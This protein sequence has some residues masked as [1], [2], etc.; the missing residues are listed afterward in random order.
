MHSFALLPAAREIIA[1]TPVL[2]DLRTLAPVQHGNNTTVVR[3]YMGLQ[4]QIKFAHR[5]PGNVMVIIERVYISYECADAPTST[6]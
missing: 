2:S 6:D 1:N 5:A 4:R 3:S